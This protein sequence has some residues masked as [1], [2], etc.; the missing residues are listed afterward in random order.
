MYIRKIN[1]FRYFLVIQHKKYVN[2]FLFVFLN[3]KNITHMYKEYI[4]RISGVVYRTNINVK[5]EV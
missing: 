5:V 1:K 4:M 2:K 3:A